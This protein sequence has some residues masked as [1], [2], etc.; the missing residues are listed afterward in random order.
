V[1]SLR[2]IALVFTTARIEGLE[3][4]WHEGWKS[5]G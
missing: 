4:Q 5:N 2:E 1:P 3:K